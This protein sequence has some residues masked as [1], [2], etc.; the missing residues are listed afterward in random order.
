MPWNYRVIIT[1]NKDPES[2]DAQILSAFYDH[3]TDKIPH[4]WGTVP[5]NMHVVTNVYEMAVYEMHDRHSK[6]SSA[7]NKP[8]LIVRYDEINKREYLEEVTPEFISDHF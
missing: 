5:A 2:Y 8:W 7:L 1:Q 3:E 4:S 6:M